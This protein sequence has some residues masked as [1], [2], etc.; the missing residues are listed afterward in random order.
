MNDMLLE[1]FTDDE[2]KRALFK[3]FPTKAPGLDGFPTHFFQQHWDI[4]GAEVWLVVLRVLNGEENVEDINSTC[5]VL[6]PKV[7][8][9]EDI[10]QFLLIIPMSYIK[11]LQKCWLWVDMIMQLVSSVSFSVLVNGDWLESFKP[12][13]GIRQGDPL[14]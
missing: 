2:V 4:C 5:I 8:C 9:P 1:P 11:L 6:I 12:T 3:L 7:E 10:G 14:V 13:C